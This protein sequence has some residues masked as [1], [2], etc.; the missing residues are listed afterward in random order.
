[1]IPLLVGCILFLTGCHHFAQDAELKRNFLANRASFTRLVEMA[2]IDNSYRQIHNS[3]GS[4][5]P[6]G[7]D[8]GRYAEY[9]KLF[10]FAGLVI[11]INHYVEFPKALFLVA[12]ASAA[13]GGGAFSNGYAFCRCSLAPVVKNTRDPIPALL[14]DADGKHFRVFSPIESNRYLFYE[15][16]NGQLHASQ[17][18]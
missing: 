10:D 15:F 5:G 7:M 6:N 17:S 18:Y 8:A 13:L 12:D 9:K 2:K 4:I 3:F 11:G 14:M 1:M 16:G